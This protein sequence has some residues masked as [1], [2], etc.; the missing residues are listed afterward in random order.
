MDFQCD[1]CG[2]KYHVADEKLQGRAAS[3]FKC[4]KCENM[5]LL[6][7]QGTNAPSV[8][9]PPADLAEVAPA[10]PSPLRAP[11]G[12]VQMR[13]AT[14]A[15]PRA[16][17]VP[18]V[19]RPRPATTSG[20]A[21]SSGPGRPAISA[22]RVEPTATPSTD[23]DDHGWFAGIRDVPV[24][25]VS[26]AELQTHITA[27]DVT[28]DTLV[29]RDGFGDWRPLRAVPALKDLLPGLRVVTQRPSHPPLHSFAESDGDATMVSDQGP[30]L[31]AA[32]LKAAGPVHDQRLQEAP[33][34]KLS[35]L[36]DEQLRAIRLPP[37]GER[38]SERPPAPAVAKSPIASSLS[39]TSPPR[40]PSAPPRPS[41]PAGPGVRDLPLQTVCRILFSAPCFQT[42]ESAP[43]STI[44]HSG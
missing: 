43:G 21:Y 24:G 8:A 30:S 35:A 2:Q 9:P 18:G 44:Y 39:K 40:A 6:S 34:R 42:I 41:T 12:T 32:A 16:S 13:P 37:V 27:G 38:P 1:R 11:T 36:T 23:A 3:R 33:T 20:P 25:P 26:R 7:A 4:K 5:I 29:W 10:G 31:V 28:G 15:I 14:G 19:P 17:G 22:A